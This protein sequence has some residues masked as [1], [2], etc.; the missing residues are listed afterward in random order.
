MLSFI[1]LHDEN[2]RDG[3]IEIQIQVLGQVVEELNT[4]HDLPESETSK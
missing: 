1:G 2:L 3:I 4:F